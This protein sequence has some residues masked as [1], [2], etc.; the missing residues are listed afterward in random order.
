MGSR[1]FYEAPE[2]AAF[3]RR[4]AAALVRRAADGD[5]E[6]LSCIQ[7]S[8]AAFESALDAAAR[9]AHGAG[10]SW[11]DIARELG[12]TRQAAWQRFSERKTAQ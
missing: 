9:A 4:T 2:M 11:T 1:S 3:L 7:E 12:M 8:T 6:I 10:Y 5:L